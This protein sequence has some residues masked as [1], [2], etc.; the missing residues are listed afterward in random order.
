MSNMYYCAIHNSGDIAPTDLKEVF[1]TDQS[2]ETIWDETLAQYVTNPNFVPNS[3]LTLKDEQSS[4]MRDELQLVG[5]STNGWSTTWPI[6]E[7]RDKI[8]AFHAGDVEWT[9]GPIPYV[10]SLSALV[11]LGH[12][13]GATHLVMI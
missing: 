2:E 10:E 1:E 11:D 7:V 4:Y 3:V 12:R 13:M 8:T 6:T 5:A 9:D